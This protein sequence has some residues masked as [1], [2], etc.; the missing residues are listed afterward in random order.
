MPLLKQTKQ[1][2]KQP[3]HSKYS[4]MESE[5]LQILK[6]SHRKNV[7]QT[8][9]SQLTSMKVRLQIGLEEGES[10]T[11]WRNYPQLPTPILGKTDKSE[12]YKYVHHLK[13]GSRS[14]FIYHH[15]I[16]LG[17]HIL[18]TRITEPKIVPK[19]ELPNLEPSPT[20]TKTTKNISASSMCLLLYIHAQHA[21]RIHGVD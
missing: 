9:H 16:Q 12:D 8:S 2:Y 10:T 13:W 19:P 6:D 20:L 11:N 14:I 21:Q 5:L 3:F 17:E 1:F 4:S 18:K 15:S 7:P